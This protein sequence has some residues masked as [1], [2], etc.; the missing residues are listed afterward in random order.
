MARNDPN[1]ANT[2]TDSAA[3]SPEIGRV[4]AIADASN[5]LDENTPP[6][7]ATD[8]FPF[9]TESIAELFLVTASS[10]PQRHNTDPVPVVIV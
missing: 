7:A 6:N 3:T 4:T 9:N 5:L 2:I 1:A 10:Y 8:T